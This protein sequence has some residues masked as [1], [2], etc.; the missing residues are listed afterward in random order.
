MMTDRD[1]RQQY[2]TLQAQWR[3]HAKN[4]NR[5]Y[6]PYA[7]PNG[8]VDYVLVAEIPNVDEKKGRDR[9]RCMGRLSS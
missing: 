2:E 7:P 5:H 6:L 8:K 4:R 3:Q 1:F 9:K